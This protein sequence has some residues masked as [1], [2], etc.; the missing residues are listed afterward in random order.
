MFAPVLDSRLPLPAEEAVDFGASPASPLKEPDALPQAREENAPAKYSTIVKMGLFFSVPS[1]SP[2]C[3]AVA[4]L[5]R[6]HTT[7]DD[8]PFRPFYRGNQ[9]Q[10]PQTEDIGAVKP[11]WKTRS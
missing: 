5:T 8:T 7:A 2:Q 1:I 6:P 11:G 4:N 3:Y 9:T 10:V